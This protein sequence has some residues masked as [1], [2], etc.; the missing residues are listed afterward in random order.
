MLYCM[1][2]LS[3]VFAIG[4]YVFLKELQKLGVDISALLLSH[5]IKTT[6]ETEAMEA[7]LKSQ[8]LEGQSVNDIMG[9]Y[10]G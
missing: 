9:D 6:K 7:A 5:T 8:I 2:F 4:L 10:Y 3:V 1:W